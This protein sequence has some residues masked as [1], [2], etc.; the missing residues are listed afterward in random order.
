MKEFDCE[1]SPADPNPVA[2]DAKHVLV[3][4]VVSLEQDE[5]GER[6]AYHEAVTRLIQT[7]AQPNRRVILDCSGWWLPPDSKAIPLPPGLLE[8][9]VINWARRGAV[10]GIILPAKHPF[11][12]RAREH[13]L[14]VITSA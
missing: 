1:W 9:M 7:I 13:G 10:H 8:G 6:L 14:A 12:S 2:D 11:T 5:H 4:G 3:R